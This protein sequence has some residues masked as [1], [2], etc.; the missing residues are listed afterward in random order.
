[1]FLAQAMPIA[2]INA[3]GLVDRLGRRVG[4]YLAG[5]LEMQRAIVTRYFLI[6]N[7]QIDVETAQTP[8]CMGE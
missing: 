7:H 8:V 6:Q 4:L 5:Q 1:M 3:A 2:K